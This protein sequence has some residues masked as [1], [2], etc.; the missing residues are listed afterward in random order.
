MKIKFV[1]KFNKI[2]AGT[3]VTITDRYGK[4]LIEKE[5]AEEVTDKPKKE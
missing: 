4:E 2:K 5:V 1:K 3:V